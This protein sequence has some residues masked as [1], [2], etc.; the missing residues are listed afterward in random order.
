MKQ[1]VTREPWWAQPPKPGQS[2]KDCTWGYLERFDDGSFSFDQANRPSDE[3]IQNRKGCRV[4]PHSTSPSTGILQGKETSMSAN[5]IQE[6]QGVL[7]DIAEQKR[8]R[9]TGSEYKEVIAAIEAQPKDIESLHIARQLVAKLAQHQGHESEAPFRDES[10]NRVFNVEKMPAAPAEGDERLRERVIAGTT[11]FKSREFDHTSEPSK[12]NDRGEPG[13]LVHGKRLDVFHNTE[14]P[15][16]KFEVFQVRTSTHIPY[17]TG[18]PGKPVDGER[19][20]HGVFHSFEEAGKSIDKT[21]GVV[22]H[23]EMIRQRQAE[24]GIH[25]KEAPPAPKPRA[26]RPA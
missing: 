13:R 18:I 6:W 20:P 24:H 9:L 5:S 12:L 22:R 10:L 2:D 4:P 15:G 26:P 17:S 19:K 7:Q 11:I 3:E 8:H 25:W 16:D 1:L 23:S 14:G 21:V